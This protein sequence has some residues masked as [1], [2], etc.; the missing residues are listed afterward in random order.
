MLTCMLGSYAKNYA[1][2]IDQSLLA[3][4]DSLK[5]AKC[6][7][8][9]PALNF[10][11][12][13]ISLQVLGRCF[14]FFTLCYQLAAQTRN[15]FHTTTLLRLRDKLRG[16]VSRIFLPLCYFN[17]QRTKTPPTRSRLEFDPSYHP[18]S[19]HIP[20]SL[21]PSPPPAFFIAHF[22][23]CPCLFFFTSLLTW[24]TEIKQHWTINRDTVEA[25]VSDHLGNSRKRHN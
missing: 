6:E 1:S 23:F 21:Q 25:L 3:G 17:F 14:A 7:I 22:Y 11:R 4:W 9:K 8:Q 24:I 18:P 12:D 13:I 5:A 10:S 15:S 20:S 2:T 16:F 19:L